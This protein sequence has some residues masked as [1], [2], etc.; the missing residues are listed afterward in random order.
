MNRRARTPIVLGAALVLVG[1]TATVG[2]IR[3]LEVVGASMTPTLAPGDHVLVIRIP[4]AWR[5]RPGDLI[6]FPDPRPARVAGAP[7]L[8][9]KR[10]ETAGP[11]GIEVRGDNL[12]ASTDGRTFGAVPR[13]S[14]VGLVVYRYAPRHRAG[15]LQ[16][17]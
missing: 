1:A 8:L 4:G 13:R 3:R 7:R 10:V 5:L 2:M 11:E 9:V 12:V 17:P 15:R 16:W 6:A 14:V